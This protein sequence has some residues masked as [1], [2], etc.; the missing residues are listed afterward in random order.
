MTC[1]AAPSTSSAAIPSRSRLSDRADASYAALLKY[2]D[3]LDE[4]Q[5]LL[6]T[7]LAEAR[8]S[9]DLSSI[10]YI[11]AHLPHIACGKGSSPGPGSSLKSSWTWPSRA[12]WLRWRAARFNL[13]H[14]MAHEGRLDEAVDMLGTPRNG[15]MTTNW[16]RLRTSE[17][18]GF[19]ALSRGDPVTAA[20]ISIAGMPW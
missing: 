19:V 2:A 7:L 15:V 3:E 11:L 14:V 20:A 16:D 18:L 8:A 1:S 6:L 9:A 17:A 10:A 5:S 12:A 13:G 4:A